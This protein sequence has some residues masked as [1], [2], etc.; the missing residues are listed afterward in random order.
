VRE[1]LQRHIR[2]HTGDKPYTC[3]ICDKGFGQN[4]NLQR[5]IRTRTCDKGFN[6]NSHLQQHIRTHTCTNG[7]AKKVSRYFELICVIDPAIIKFNQVL[8]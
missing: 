7:H 6:R 2:T 4:Q 5:H 3:D 8:S 1:D